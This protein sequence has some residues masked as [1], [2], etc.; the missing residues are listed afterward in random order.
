MVHRK[1]LVRLMRKYLM[2]LLAHY[3]IQVIVIQLPQEQVLLKINTVI[4]LVRLQP[5]LLP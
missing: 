3:I 4:I 5:Q 2:F 1:Q